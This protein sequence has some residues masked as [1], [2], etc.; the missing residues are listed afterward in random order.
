[1]QRSVKISDRVVATRHELRVASPEAT[2]KL[3]T[4]RLTGDVVQLCGGSASVVQRN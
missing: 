2:G 4:V 3:T 1:M